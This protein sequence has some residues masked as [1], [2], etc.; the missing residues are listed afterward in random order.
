MNNELYQLAGHISDHF[1]GNSDISQEEG[2]IYVAD[3]IRHLFDDKRRLDWL[4]RAKGDLNEC[5]GRWYVAGVNWVAS[6]DSDTPRGAIDDKM[7][8]MPL[9]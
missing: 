2:R 5:D 9:K 6:K 8:E 3:K 7:V 1:V 4:E